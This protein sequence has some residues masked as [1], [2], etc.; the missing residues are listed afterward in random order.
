MKK[1]SLLA[2]SLCVSLIF[3]GILTTFPIAVTAQ[4]DS[5][6]ITSHLISLV[7]TTNNDGLIRYQY[8]DYE[9]N[10]VSL[11]TSS[12][13]TSSKKRAAALPSSYD[14]REYGWVT[15]IRN[16]GVSGGCWAFG[17]LKSLESSS[18]MNNLT[19]LNDTD[20]SENHLLWYAYHP[21]TDTS[22]PLYG[23]ALTAENVSSGDYYM[24]G[25]NTYIA[26]YT[27]ANW[28]GAVNEKKAP[29]SADSKSKMT[30][31]AS[32]MESQPESLRTESDIHLKE[33][34]LYDDGE[35]SDIKQAI[36]DHGS[37]DVSLYFDTSNMYQNAAKTITSAYDSTHSDKEANHCVT[38]VGWDD[39]FNTFSTQAPGSGAWLVANSYGTTYDMSS[40]GYYWV[41]YYDTSLN[42]FSTFEGED[43]SRYD[44]AFQYD[45]MGYNIF[46]TSSSDLSFANV[47]TNESQTKTTLSSVGFYTLSNQQPYQIKIYRKLTEAYPTSGTLVSSCTTDGTV[48]WKGYHTIDLKKSVTVNAGETFSVVV[49]FQSNGNEIYLPLEGESSSDV[50]HSSAKGQ[51]FVLL[52]SKSGWCD[53]TNLVSNKTTTNLNNVCLK[54]FGK[55]K[56]TTATAETAL[57]LAKTKYTIGTGETFTIPVS[58]SAQP[59]SF[60]SADES[61]A[62]VDDEGTVTGNSTGSTT[63]L[64]TAN[65][66]AKATITL[67]V[68]AA[69][70]SVSVTALKTRILRG[71]SVLLRVSP[72]AGSASYQNT[73][74]SSRPRIATV[75]SSGRVRGRKKGTAWIT[76]KTY[77]K[78]KARIKIRVV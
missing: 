14:S 57:P 13:S 28:W 74:S 16:Q 71:Y 6:D 61:V 15:P 37:V 5:D 60:E 34:N 67:R 78:K 27:L 65:S 23:D 18:I 66:G 54:V 47:F 3:S 56:K 62:S 63:I 19:S 10:E 69:P 75:N 11:P 12:P 2:A 25:G 44:T 35:R 58:S 41:S 30:A 21:S 52:N 49:T 7:E 45:G 22:D 4:A 40:N 73:F 24:Q 42:E 51:S 33:M 26:A 72:N 36:I 48:S 59:L 70:D 76:V 39:T 68:K 64:V 38:I 9:G 1:K 46:Y 29:F 55:S 31:M 50:Q 77:N 20:Y 8:E 53:S 32:S 43:A 17:A